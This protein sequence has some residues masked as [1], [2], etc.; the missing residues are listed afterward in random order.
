MPVLYPTAMNNT[1]DDFTMMLFACENI[2]W[3]ALSEAIKAKLGIKPYWG[4]PLLNP[5]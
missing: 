4:N 5:H 1:I 2:L 3:T